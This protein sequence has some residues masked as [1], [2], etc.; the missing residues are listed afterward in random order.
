MCGVFGEIVCWQKEKGEKKSLAG[1]Q[2]FLYWNACMEEHWV[3]GDAVYPRWPRAQN[4]EW[5]DMK[6]TFGVF[7]G[8][9]DTTRKSLVQ[10]FVTSF[11]FQGEWCKNIVLHRDVFQQRARAPNASPNPRCS[12]QGHFFVPPPFISSHPFCFNPSEWRARSISH[13]LL[14]F[15]V[16]LQRSVYVRSLQ[17]ETL[18]AK[19]HI[20][21]PW[22]CLQDSYIKH[23]EVC[24]FY[25]IFFFLG[26]GVG[27]L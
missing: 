2:G 27:S 25:F 13:Y 11:F 3:A 10:C 8:G 18:E 12:S 20:L 22:Q 24:S 16:C 6:M 15:R 23:D 21:S 1:S 4:A 19:S 7:L 5:Q 9:R 17:E 14:P 26:E